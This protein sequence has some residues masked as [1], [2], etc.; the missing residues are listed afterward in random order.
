MCSTPKGFLVI[1]VADVAAYG[2]PWPCH[3]TQSKAQSA[4][5]V[6]YSFQGSIKFAESHSITLVGKRLLIVDR[7]L[8]DKG[9]GLLV[10]GSSALNVTLQGL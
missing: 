9:S 8:T 10:L 4:L 2:Q 6:W 5:K 1:L 3:P 7:H